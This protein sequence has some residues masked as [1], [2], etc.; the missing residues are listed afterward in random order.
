MLVSTRNF[1]KTKN[2]TNEK[3]TFET[4]KIRKYT[5]CGLRNL[6]GT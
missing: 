1:A 5:F 2:F 4:K 6:K 3:K